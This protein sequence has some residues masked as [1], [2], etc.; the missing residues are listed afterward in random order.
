MPGNANILRGNKTYTVFGFE[1]CVSC[2]WL[3][4]N[5]SIVKLSND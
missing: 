2:K 1:Y 5:V 4:K 3:S